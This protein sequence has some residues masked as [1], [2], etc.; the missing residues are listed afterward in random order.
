MGKCI[1]GFILGVS[2]VV[3][4]W[5]PFFPILTLAAAIV[6]LCMANSGSKQLAEEGN[7]SGFAIAGKILSLIGIILSALLLVIT[8]SVCTCTACLASLDPYADSSYSGGYYY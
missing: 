2:A 3:L 7:G 1:A 4:A 6:G 8:F 5:I